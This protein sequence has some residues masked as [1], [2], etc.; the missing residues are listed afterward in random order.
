MKKHELLRIWYKTDTFK[1]FAWSSA[2][3]LTGYRVADFFEPPS[4]YTN[5]LTA[6]IAPPAKLV[7][8]VHQ[9]ATSI[10]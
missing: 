2:L 1:I 10:G 9:L 6:P 4:Y 8:Q 3:G 5:K 7:A